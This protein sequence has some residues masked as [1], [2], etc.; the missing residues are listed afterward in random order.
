MAQKGA[1]K[2]IIPDR[3]TAQWHSLDSPIDES[4]SSTTPQHNE[5]IM[6]R[7]DPIIDDIV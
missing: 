1:G 3:V 4:L 2:I 6:L 5:K 7:L